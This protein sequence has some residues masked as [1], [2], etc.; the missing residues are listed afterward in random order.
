MNR[1]Y[2]AAS[3]NLPIP[4]VAPETTG[5]PTGRGRRDFEPE[6]TNMSAFIVED[7]VINRVLGFLWCER[8]NSCYQRILRDEQG[9][10]ILTDEGRDKLGRAMF[11]L[12]CNAVEQ[13]YGEGEAKEFRPLDYRPGIAL[14]NKVQA[15]KSLRCWLY[16]CMEGDVPETSLLYA[17]MQRISDEMAHEIVSN[18]DAYE[19]ARW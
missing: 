9:I 19:K 7:E 13:R 2:K 4:Q 15:Y 14:C 3:N 18:L 10:E 8:S 5:T 17:T 6:A 1:N 11:E 12:N 16:Q